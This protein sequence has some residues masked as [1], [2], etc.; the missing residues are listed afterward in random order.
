MTARYVMLV[1]MA[2]ATRDSPLC[3]SLTCGPGIFI[4]LTGPDRVII[5]INQTHLIVL[6]AAFSLENNK[7]LHQHSLY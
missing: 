5:M 2:D 1:L 6:L 4:I 7:F 3:Q